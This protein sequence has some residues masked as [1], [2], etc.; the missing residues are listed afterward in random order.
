MPEVD[1]VPEVRY[2]AERCPKTPVFVPTQTI[3]YVGDEMSQR[4]YSH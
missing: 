4:T 3:S 1:G 2:Q